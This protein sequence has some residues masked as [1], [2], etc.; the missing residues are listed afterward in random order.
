MNKSQ[1]VYTTPQIEPP[2]FRYYPGQL[3]YLSRVAV[4]DAALVAADVGTGKSLMAV[5]LIRCK[6]EELG[7]DGQRR[8]CGRALIIA[9]GGTLRSN[10]EDED[11]DSEEEGEPG[12]PAAQWRSWCAHGAGPAPDPG[13]GR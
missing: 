4:K 5:S 7:T 11:S 1:L 8:F 12:V 13:C 9:P 3:D 6:L 2:T 10:E